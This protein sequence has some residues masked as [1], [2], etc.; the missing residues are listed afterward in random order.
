LKAQKSWSLSLVAI[1]LRL[2]AWGLRLFS[3]ALRL[4]ACSLG[5]VAC[6]IYN[7]SLR[8]SSLHPKKAQQFADLAKA[9]PVV[10]IVF[11]V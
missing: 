7:I 10:A 3:S 11:N 1:S 6:R 2:V 4:E 5:L 8:F 9:G